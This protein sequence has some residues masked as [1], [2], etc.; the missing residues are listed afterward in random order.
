LEALTILEKAFSKEH[1]DYAW[2]L[3][4]LAELYNITGKI[5]K[6]EPLWL[7]AL[8]IREK[9]LGREHP[10]YAESLNYLAIMY[11]DIG[12]TEKAESLYLE[13]NE[14]ERYL[15]IKASHHLSERELLGYIDKF[16]DRQ[17][18]FLSFAQKQAGVSES[19][20]DNTLFYKGFL[21][22]ATQQVNRLAQTDSTSMEMFLRLKAYHRRLAAEYAIPLTER[23]VVAEL[24]EKANSLE[25]ELTRR[26]AGFGT[27]LRQVTWQEVQAQLR[28]GEAAIEFVHYRYYDPDLT[29]SIMY[30]ALLLQPGDEQPQFISLFEEKSLDSLFGSHIERR[31]DYVSDLY[32]F[33]E[34]GLVAAGKPKKTLYELIWQPLASQLGDI[35]KIYFSPS[36]LLHRLNLGA[37]PVSD[38]QT[39]SD[40]FNFVQVNS[41]RQLVI[42]DQSISSS[43]DA[44][45][46]GGVQYDMD[47]ISFVSINEKLLSNDALVTRGELSFLYANPALRGGT[48]WRYL[49][50]TEKEVSAIAKMLSTAEIQ[51]ETRIGFSATEE[52][53]RQCGQ[54]KSP[55]IIHLATH[56]FFFPDPVDKLKT[57]QLAIGNDDLVFKISDHPMI[58][59]GLILAGGNHVWR[60]KPALTGMQDGILTAYEISQMNLSNTELVVLSACETG[61]GDIKGNEGV[62]GLQRAFK[63]A[64]VQYLI[65]SLWKV[66]DRATKDFMITFY[67]HWLEDRMAIPKAFRQTQKEMK[68]RFYSPFLWAGFVLV[69]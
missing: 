23:K 49:N 24:E 64:G 62:Y 5:E 47:S 66:D 26:V 34:R 16:A 50:H 52:A 28:A 13:V 44:I 30:A 63:I 15:L 53:F 35:Q 18:R 41:T 32:S 57:K 31:A 6:A 46:F 27:A 14:I 58:R 19:A 10:D 48:F 69:E 9:V 22:N 54:G 12:K 17:N 42:R 56:G 59:S 11:N 51:T 55:R 40:Q 43:N 68:E 21:L 33:K 25:K 67:Q 45:L 20:Y 1:P 29:D 7:E 38:E 37:I 61:L 39:L 2:S 60:G 65:M 8:A 4:G 36:G 3:I